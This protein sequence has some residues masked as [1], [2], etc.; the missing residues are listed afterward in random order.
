ML[1]AAMQNE[2]LPFFLPDC[3]VKLFQCIKSHSAEQ[4]SL[5]PL[6]FFPLLAGGLTA[7]IG[8][9]VLLQTPPFPQKYH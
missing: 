6:G 1:L 8:I 5:V 9:S 4:A 2:D 7:V 3:Q